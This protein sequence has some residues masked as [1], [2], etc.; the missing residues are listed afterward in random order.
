MCRRQGLVKFIGLRPTLRVPNR[1]PRRDDLHPR[2]DAA[3]AVADQNHAMLSTVYL[4]DCGK[5]FAQPH[6]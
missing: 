3:H 4:I 6:G 2:Y 1:A 5:L